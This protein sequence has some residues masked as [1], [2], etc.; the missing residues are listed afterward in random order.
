MRS[1]PLYADGKVYAFTA[2]GRWAILEPDAKRGAKILK[3]GRLNRGEE[4]HGSPICSHGRIYLPTTGGLYC[5]ADS[6]KQPGVTEMK[7]LP[8]ETPVA[9]DMTPAHL[10]VMPADVLLKPGESHQFTARLFNA[11]GQLLGNACLLYTSPSPRDATL[12]RMP[13]SA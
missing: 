13:S 5:L 11:K 10:Q 3:K 12:S 2:N 9:D 7:P 1:S 8:V 6:S 4:T